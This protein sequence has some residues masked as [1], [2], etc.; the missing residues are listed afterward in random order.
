MKKMKLIA[1]TVAMAVGLMACGKTNSSETATAAKADASQTADAGS[2]EVAEVIMQWPSMGGS[3]PEGFDDVENAVNEITMKEIGV[4]V[5]LEPVDWTNLANETSLAVSSGEQVDLC[6]SLFTGVGDLV[7]SGAIQPLG[8]L[9]ETYGK[10]I[11]KSLDTAIAGGYYNNELYA[12]PKIAQTGD[13]R[14]F[15]CSTK[16]LEKYN[17]NISEDKVYSLQELEEIFATVKAGEGSSF[18]PIGGTYDDISLGMLQGAYGEIDALGSTPASGVLMLCDSFEDM[19]VQ[20]LFAA[21]RYGEY[22]AKMY[23]WA[24]KGYFSADAG[25]NTIMGQDQLAGGNYFGW[26]TTVVPGA[27]Q[28]YES[29][30]GIAMTAIKLIDPYST[31]RSLNSVLWSIPIT[32]ANPEKAMQLLNLIY[33]DD[34]IGT[35]LLHGKEGVS[36][37]VKEENENSRVIDY[38]EGLDSNTV[39]YTQPF[40]VYGVETDLPVRYPLA[41]DYAETTRSFNESITHVSPALGYTFVSDSVASEFAAVTSVIDQYH[42]TIDTGAAD[43]SEVLPKFREALEAAGIQKIIEE[44]QRQL[45]EWKAQQ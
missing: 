28:N 3:V 37:V 39:P 18:Y 38:P 23:D 34:R 10:D 45:D 26:F 8:N 2:D 25:T 42:I 21:D 44:N 40:G 1:F 22:A 11:A 20:N 31:Q 29:Q 15:M 16:I 19:K 17:I 41:I 27:A 32:S 35:L 24:Q 13:V 6:L 12:I 4:K 14:G 9:Y 7:S 36:Y 43:P 30:T 33:K 5:V